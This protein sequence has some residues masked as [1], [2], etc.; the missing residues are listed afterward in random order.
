MVG[1]PAVVELAPPPSSSDPQAATSAANETA[2]PAVKKLRRSIA[3]ALPPLL[4]SSSS[5]ADR[6]CIV[7]HPAGDQ[8]PDA[9]GSQVGRQ[10]RTGAMPRALIEATVGRSSTKRASGSSGPLKNM[11]GS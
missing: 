4:G 10:R 11:A 3:M 2:P 8:L 6:R 1:E 7:A 9:Y 5:V